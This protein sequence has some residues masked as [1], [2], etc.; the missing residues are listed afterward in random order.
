MNKRRLLGFIFII[1]S[2]FT[3]VA[4][5]NKAITELPDLTGY[6]RSEINNVFNN[7]NK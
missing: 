1:L 2:I 5:G 6:S 3:L 4:C 7:S